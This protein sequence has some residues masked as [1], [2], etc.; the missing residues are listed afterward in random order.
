[1]C[2]LYTVWIIPM[3]SPKQLVTIFGLSPF[4]C[5]NLCSVNNVSYYLL[6]IRFPPNRNLTTSKSYFPWKCTCTCKQ[7]FNAF[8]L[9]SLTVSSTM[10]TL[11]V[12]SFKTITWFWIIFWEVDRQNLFSNAFSFLLEGSKV[13]A[14]FRL[15]WCPLEE[16][17][18]I[19]YW[20]MP[21]FK[22]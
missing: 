3:L 5:N 2:T 8:S 18:N 11:N 20:N 15:Y 10:Y 6:F 19:K 17:F 16:D 21:K 1:M 14:I 12:N 13:M 4:I 9:I 22:S 7:I